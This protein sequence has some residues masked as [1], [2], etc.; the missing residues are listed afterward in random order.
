LYFQKR[1]YPKNFASKVDEFSKQR[2]GYAIRKI[3]KIP[4]K[5]ESEICGAPVDYVGSIDEMLVFDS[6]PTKV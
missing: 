2:I 3:F 6:C 1:F 5:S 4:V